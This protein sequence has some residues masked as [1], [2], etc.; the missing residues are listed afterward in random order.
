MVVF[1]GCNSLLRLELYVKMVLL[2]TSLM[3]SI[4]AR[5]SHFLHSN[6]K[7]FDDG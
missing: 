6:D 2:K 7:K 4:E 1:A 5:T 3:I